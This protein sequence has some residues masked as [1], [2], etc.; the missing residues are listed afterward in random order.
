MSTVPLAFKHFERHSVSLIYLFI[1]AL[2]WRA[3]EPR[4]LRSRAIIPR[5]CIR[6][7]VMCSARAAP[8]PRL[9]TLLYCAFAS[10]LRRRA[11]ACGAQLWGRHSMIP[12]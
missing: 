7:P 1:C 12:Y 2:A 3:V 11:S 9:P 10:G 5:Y 6:G 8:I 4:R